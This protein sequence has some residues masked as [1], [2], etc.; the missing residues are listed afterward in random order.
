MQHLLS[1][2]P[3][4]VRW[5]YEGWVHTATM[6]MMWGR[7]LQSKCPQLMHPSRK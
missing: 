3:K 1:N 6:K 4:E 7:R 2:K 5:Q